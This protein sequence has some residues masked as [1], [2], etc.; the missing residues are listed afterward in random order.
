MAFDV[1]TVLRQVPQTRR[2]ARGRRPSVKLVRRGLNLAIVLALVP[3]ILMGVAGAGVWSGMMAW[4]EGFAAFAV[5]ASPRL[6]LVTIGAGVLGLI[7]ALFAD[8]DRLW[9][10]ALLALSITAT[11]VAGYVWS[12][13]EP[14]AAVEVGAAA[15]PS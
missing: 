11:T 10:R 6:A 2:R 8:F 12:R 14:P 7:G 9:L 1:Q 5:W 13:A 3:S 15:E 4:T